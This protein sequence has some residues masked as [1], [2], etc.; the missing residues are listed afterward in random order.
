MLKTMEQSRSGEVY[1][2]K[3]EVF[4]ETGTKKGQ[5]PPALAKDKSEYKVLEV[6]CFQDIQVRL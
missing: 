5:I 2:P 3:L 4:K 1:I 6:P